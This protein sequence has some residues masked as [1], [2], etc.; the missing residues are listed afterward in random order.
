MAG[1]SYGAATARETSRKAATGQSTNLLSPNSAA[2]GSQAAR[3]RKSSLSANGFFIDYSCTRRRSQLAPSGLVLAGAPA[4]SGQYGGQRHHSHQFESTA[5]GAASVLA[6][7]QFLRTYV[8]P[9]RRPSSGG[10]S[11]GGSFCV[12]GASSHSDAM[13][14]LRRPTSPAAAASIAGSRKTSIFDPP[15]HSL[16]AAQRRKSTITGGGGGCPLAPGAVEQAATMMAVSRQAAACLQRHGQRTKSK[17]ELVQSVPVIGCSPTSI[18]ASLAALNETHRYEKLLRKL[19]VHRRR[20]ERRQRRKL[21]AG[22]AGAQSENWLS[23]SSAASASSS[24]SSSSSASGCSSAGS[25]DESSSRRRAVAA[26]AAARRRRKSTLAAITRDATELIR[27]AAAGSQRRKSRRHDRLSFSSTLSF[28]SS[29]ASLP[30]IDRLIDELER[31]ETGA[32]L[33]YDYDDDDDDY[34]YYCDRYDELYGGGGAKSADE[35]ALRSG[36]EQPLQKGAESR[37]RRSMIRRAMGRLAASITAR[38]SV[39]NK[40]RRADT[41]SGSPLDV[42]CRRPQRRRSISVAAN[43][44]YWHYYYYLRDKSLSDAP[45]DLLGASSSAATPIGCESA[46]RRARLYVNYALAR[47]DIL[48][49]SKAPFKVEDGSLLQLQQV[50]LRPVA[51]V[52]ESGS[53]TRPLEFGQGGSGSD[54]S[55]TL[56]TTSHEKASDASTSRNSSSLSLRESLTTRS[57]VREPAQPQQQPQRHQ[58]KQRD[59]QVA[60]IAGHSISSQSIRTLGGSDSFCYSPSAAAAQ[61]Q[62]SPSG[63]MFARTA[64]PPPTGELDGAVETARSHGNLL[65]AS[66]CCRVVGGGGSGG[67]LSSRR[68]LSGCSSASGRSAASQ[69]PRLSVAASSCGG[70]G[71]AGWSRT[72]SSAA[73]LAGSSQLASSASSSSSDELDEFDRLS[74]RHRPA[75]EKALREGSRELRRQRRDARNRLSTRSAR[76]APATRRPVDCGSGGAAAEPHGSTRRRRTFLSC[77]ALASAEQAA[78]RSGAAAA[79]AAEHQPAQR[80][81]CFARA[82]LEADDYLL[83]ARRS[84][85]RP[86]KSE[87]AAAAVSAR[88]SWLGEGVAARN[89]NAAR[90]GQANN[91][92]NQRRS[93]SAARQ[94][95]AATKPAAANYPHQDW[96]PEQRSPAAGRLGPEQA[97]AS[98]ANSSRSSSA[99]SG[100]AR[101]CAAAASSGRRDSNEVGARDERAANKNDNSTIAAAAKQR[102]K[103][104]SSS[105]SRPPEAGP[106][107]AGAAANTCTGR[108]AVG[109][110]QLSA[111]RGE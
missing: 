75:A 54:L 68:S 26:S 15:G 100:A 57:S 14:L 63:Q 12:G 24:S 102:E 95:S 89:Y 103:Q 28:A 104:F 74:C 13:Q 110:Q 35:L 84:F 31:G 25:S 41:A 81:Y 97:T 8:S 60:T 51:T 59:L 45:E 20:K 22:A 17:G 55:L 58:Q 66:G 32:G 27:S 19:R 36:A 62:I 76:P 33:D 30:S 44:N 83:S 79:A 21:A 82:E 38:R 78:G 47:L 107:S 67:P 73:S 93:G 111:A 43:L 92:D 88:A 6:R 56:S 2:A 16:V 108:L 23:S 48:N 64:T 5:S 109:Q 71:G 96:R 85:R 99:S 90:A 98:L 65:E 69:S 94:A 101:R 106:S 61:Q 7:N 10:R 53:P 18:R 49:S 86:Q 87:A 46:E 9:V 105:S 72:A 40:H 11:S 29:H 80:A 77:D 70:G 37:K 1:N 3:R 50:Q 52:S 39:R 4:S 91:D 42:D 34:Y